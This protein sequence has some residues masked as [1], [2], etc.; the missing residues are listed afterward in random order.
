MA[1]APDP[2]TSAASDLQ[3]VNVVSF[4]KNP[5]AELYIDALQENG[6]E[7]LEDRNIH[8]LQD[9]T[10][11]K[12][13]VILDQDMSEERMTEIMEKYEKMC[14][15]DPLMSLRFFCLK[16]D[17]EISNTNDRLRIIDIKNTVLPAAFPVRMNRDL[18]KARLPAFLRKNYNV[19]ISDVLE[20]IGEV[21]YR[22]IV[23][24]KYEK[25]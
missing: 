16:W 18:F 4:S 6:A 17:K 5:K 11:Q 20:P 24:R 13:A 12:L 19:E 15:Q 3:T 7:M 14:E 8:S 9:I 22:P 10:R 21:H 25:E 2:S 1:L 23:I